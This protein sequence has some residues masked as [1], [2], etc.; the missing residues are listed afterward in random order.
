[1]SLSPLHSSTFPRVKS[2]PNFQN[3]LRKATNVLVQPLLLL[4]WIIQRIE[5]NDHA[6][7]LR[8]HDTAIFLTK[9]A[10]LVL[11]IILHPL[12]DGLVLL[13]LCHVDPALLEEIVNVDLEV[14][15]VVVDVYHQGA[16][17]ESKEA[18][19]WGCG[20]GS[21]WIEGENG[22]GLS[23]LVGLRGLE[24]IRKTVKV[25]ASIGSLL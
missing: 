12:Q 5:L 7:D 2:S 23:L 8:L 6:H 16:L 17:V 25:L 20:L 1:M 3:L 4:L 18:C 13:A 24:E 19:N 21:S 10:C 9:Y 14:E 11:D 15:H 22:R